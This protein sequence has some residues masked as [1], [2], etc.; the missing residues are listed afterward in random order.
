M[1]IIEMSRSNRGSKRFANAQYLSVSTVNS[2]DE[3]VFSLS[4]DVVKELRWVIG[5]NIKIVFDDESHLIT[6]ARTLSNKGYTLCGRSKN[7]R[8]PGMVAG[9]SIRIMARGVI[10]PTEFTEIT[11]E[12]C[13][14]D[15]TS[16]TFVMPGQS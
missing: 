10:K 15:G 16:I 11:K 14:I 8:V 5:D 6:L 2:R 7:T 12:D 1:A 13:V 3:I 9:G 4:K